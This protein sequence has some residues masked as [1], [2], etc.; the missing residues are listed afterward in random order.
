MN[1]SRHHYISVNRQNIRGLHKKLYNS[2]RSSNILGPIWNYI[3]ENN[4][5]YK[6]RPLNR[7]LPRKKIVLEQKQW[8]NGGTTKRMG[9]LSLVFGN[10]D[11]QWEQIFESWHYCFTKTMQ[12]ILPK[13]SDIYYFSD[14]F[15]PLVRRKWQKRELIKEPS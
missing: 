15:K 5:E 3:S 13:N 9:N 8:T 12:K 1:S 6:W 10:A 11:S 4:S 7:L 2:L 14:I